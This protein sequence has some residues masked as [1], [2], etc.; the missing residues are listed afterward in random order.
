MVIQSPFVRWTLETHPTSMHGVRPMYLFL[1]AGGEKVV[2]AI[3]YPGENENPIYRP[4]HKFIRYYGQRLRLHANLQWASETTLA[5]WLN[6]VVHSSTI[7]ILFVI[8]VY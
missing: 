4:Y 5:I 6:V 2:A 8:S 3:S 1:S 7:G